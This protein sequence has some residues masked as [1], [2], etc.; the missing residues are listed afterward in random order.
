VTVT[1]D[2]AGHLY[3]ADRSNNRVLQYDRP[4]ASQVA[5]RVFG[6]GGSFAS[7]TC[8][9]GGTSTSS[10]C[11]PLGIAVDSGRHLYVADRNNS[12]VLEYDSPLASQDA[13][14]VFGHGESF[15]H[16]DCRLGGVNASSLCVATGMAV[17]RA[18]HLYIA[19]QANNRVL[20]YDSPLAPQ[21]PDRPADRVLGQGGSFNG[22]ELLV[23]HTPGYRRQT[24]PQLPG[25]RIQTTLAPGFPY[26][27]SNRRRSG[28]ARLRWQVSDGSPRTL[29]SRRPASPGWPFS[30]FLAMT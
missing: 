29:S 21:T 17:D 9:L 26:T 28:P 27:A 3:V 22:F 16:N 5:D 14:R 7:N 20:E 30:R 12:R 10:L 24:G 8:N 4:L 6:Q 18:G 1:V 19:D 2:T 13:D 25:F 15:T 11:L 23:R